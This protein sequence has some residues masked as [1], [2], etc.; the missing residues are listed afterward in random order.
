[1][2]PF[3]HPIIVCATDNI[4][5]GALKAVH[6]KGINIPTGLSIA[7]YGGYKMKEIIPLGLTTVKFQYEDAGRKAADGFVI[8]LN[9]AAL[10]INLDGNI[11]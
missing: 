3:H 11:I 8:L 1:M 2:R 5:L 9:G 4:A 7:G 10:T 6:L